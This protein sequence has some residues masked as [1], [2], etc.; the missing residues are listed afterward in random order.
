MIYKGL[1]TDEAGAR[2]KSF[3]LNSLPS[4]ARKPFWII[5]FHV[6]KEPML[7]LLII[8]GAIS[9][10][11]ADL[12]DAILLGITVLIVLGISIYQRLRTERAIQ[13]LRNLTA[14]LALVMRDGK[15]IRI[16]SIEIVPGD[17]L[18]LQ[19]GDRVAADARL[20][21]GSSLEFDESLLTGE[22]IPVTK[23]RDDLAFTGSLIVRGIGEAEVVQ[24][25]ASTELGKIGNSLQKIPYQRTRLQETIDKMVRGIGILALV[26]VVSIVLVYGLVRGNWLEGGLAAVASAMALIPEEF[27]VIL[28]LF[29]ALGAWRMAKVRVIAREPAAIEALGSMTV[30]CVDKTGTLTKNQMEIDEFHL[31]GKHL[32]AQ[33][34]PIPEDFQVL[35][36]IGALATPIH[37][38]DAMDNAFRSSANMASIPSSLTSLKEFPLTKERLAYIHIWADGLDVIAAAKGAPEHIGALCQLESVQLHRLSSQVHTAAERG[39]RVIAVARGEIANSSRSGQDPL[40]I[41]DFNFKL[42]GIAL[43]HDPIREGVPGAVRECDSAGIR[44]IMI[45]GDHPTTALAIAKE[46]G[47]GRDGRCM[48]GIELSTMSD[49]DLSTAIKS[50]SVFAR[51]LPEDKL[52]LV[53]AFQSNGEVVAMTGDGINDAPALRAADIGIAMGGRGTDVAREAAHLVITDDDFTSI[54][55]GIKRGRTIFSNIQKAMSYV[56]AIHI[57]IFGMALIPVLVADWPLI[58]LPALVA[59]HEVIIDPA[60]SIVFEVEEPDPRIMQRK[61]RRKGAGIFERSDIT[62]ALVQ[63]LG[64][65]ASV[66]AVFLYALSQGVSEEVTRSL[67]FG[68]LLL[69]NLLLILSNRSKTLTIWSSIIKRKNLAVPWIA[70]GAITLLLLLLNVPCLGE[71]FNLG[72][73]RPLDYLSM[74]AVAYIGISWLDIKK[75]IAK[76]RSGL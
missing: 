43:L 62:L 30:L 75:V 64:V 2:L 3:G 69:S 21:S 59:F 26:A 25:G 32:I 39:Y 11:L 4:E 40:T 68:S 15:R 9:F 48:V 13:A 65:F 36:R 33:S 47:I 71:A 44:T 57:P 54:V 60:C 67:T 73:I 1:S 52:R 35:V 61:P 63:G 18:V 49:E 10:L 6:I 42:L 55:A 66:F 53:R 23:S 51:V 28:T 8:A 41:E 76:K 37:P 50:C 38:I 5:A 56:I 45:T 46:I 17:L 31:D 14:P 74:F 29:M 19:E 70:T 7:I 16:S 27:P 24:T 12:G 20:L 34:E 58:L 22:S 72:E